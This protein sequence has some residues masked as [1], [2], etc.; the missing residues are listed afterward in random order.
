[1]S[2]DLALKGNMPEI[3]RIEQEL[4]KMPQVILPLLHY[5]IPGVYVRRMSISAG[6]LLTGKIHKFASIAILAEGTL[7]IAD[8]EQAYRI[9]APHVM[10]DKPGV[11]RLGFAE[12]NVT[13]ITVHHTGKEYI[14]DIEEE[15]VTSSFEEYEKLLELLEES[16]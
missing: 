11:K 4:L 9:S 13:F 10:V 1:M 8:S 15:L 2:S 5:Q 16:S 14:E 3:L 7:R 6:T 12:T